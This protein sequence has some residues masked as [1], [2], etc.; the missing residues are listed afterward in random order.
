MSYYIVHCPT[1]NKEIHLHTYKNTKVKLTCLC[2][3]LSE[4]NKQ[5]EIT[6]K[7]LEQKLNIRFYTLMNSDK[8]VIP[9][10]AVFKK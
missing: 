2:E 5:T 1:C 7:E 9:H 8:H 10:I 4:L 6:R 3:H